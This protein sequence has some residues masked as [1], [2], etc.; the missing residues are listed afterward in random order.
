M[1]EII[2]YIGKKALKHVV[3]HLVSDDNKLADKIEHVRTD[4]TGLTADVARIDRRVENVSDKLGELEDHVEADEARIDELSDTVAGM[5]S[6]KGDVDAIKEII[7]NDASPSNQLADKAYVDD[8]GE[9]L[10]AH[11]LGSDIYGSPF[12][13]YESL[14]PADGS[15]VDF[16]YQGKVVSPNANDVTVVTYD[17][18][19]ETPITRD[20]ATTR[21]RYDGTQWTFEYVIN[22]NALSRSQLLAINSGITPELNTAYSTHVSDA[23]LP[24]PSYHITS[25]ER[26]SW[27]DKVSADDL[28][29]ERK[30]RAAADNA[31]IDSI[32]AE[33]ELRSQADSALDS[34]ITALDEKIDR[35]DANGLFVN[36]ECLRYGNPDEPGESQETTGDRPVVKTIADGNGVAYDIAAK[37]LVDDVKVELT[38]D[39]TGTS[40]PWDGSGN[41]SIAAS[42]PNGSITNGKLSDGAVTLSKIHSDVKGTSIATGDSDQLVTVGAVKSYVDEQV[43]GTGSY[44]GKKTVS[45]I[46]SLLVGGLHNGDR[47]M[48]VDYGTIIHGEGGQEMT[49]QPGDDLILY[50][51]ASGEYQWQVMNG[52]FK[53]KGATLEKMM[54]GTEI[55]TSLKQDANGDLTVATSKISSA[56]SDSEGIVKLYGSTGTATDG[57]MTQKAVSDALS[58]MQTEI[59]FDGTYDKTSNKVA[60]VSS[61]TSRIGSLDAEITSMDGKNVQVTVTQEDGKLTAVNVSDLSASAQ[62]LADETDA[63]KEGDEALDE[64]VTGLEANAHSHDADERAALQSGITSDKV[65]AYDDHLVNTT[66]HITDD[67]RT[68]WNAKQ[69]AI[70]DLKS[71]RSGAAK[72]ST[73]VQP[74][75]NLSTLTDDI[76]VDA[77]VDTSSAPISGIGVKSAIGTL[78]SVAESTDGTNV[79]VKVTQVA[80]KITA[81]NITADATASSDDLDA[82]I[83]ERKEADSAIN[84]SIGKKQDILDVEY[85]AGSQSLTFNNVTISG[86]AETAKNDV[87]GIFDQAGNEFSFRDGV[88]RVD[89]LPEVDNGTLG[90]VYLLSTDSKFYML[91][92]DGSEWIS[93]SYPAD[94]ELDAESTNAIQ[95]KAVVEAI[96]DLYD[97]VDERTHLKP[98][99]TYTLVNPVSGNR[100]R[101][102]KVGNTLWMV[103]NLDE[104]V[105]LLA[106]DAT[107]FKASNYTEAYYNYDT[108]TYGHGSEYNYGR[109]YKF[110]SPDDKNALL[111]KI[112]QW[113][114]VTDSGD[115]WHVPSI[116]E[117]TDL[118]DRAQTMH[119]DCKCWA[120]LCKDPTNVAVPKDVL[121]VS[122]VASG[123]ITNSTGACTD[124][125]KLVKLAVTN[126]NERAVFTCN[127]TNAPSSV[128][129]DVLQS[130]TG[131]P[132]HTLCVRLCITLN[133][134]GSI[135]SKFSSLVEIEKATPSDTLIRDVVP[136]TA[137]QD[138]LLVTAADIA[139]YYDAKTAD[140]MTTFA[141]EYYALVNPVSKNSYRTVRVG[142]LLWLAENLDETIG[143]LATDVEHWV[144][145]TSTATE[146]YYDFDPSTAHGTPKN[147]GRYYKESVVTNNCSVINA[148]LKAWNWM[149]SDGTGWHVPTQ[150]EWQSAIDIALAKAWPKGVKNWAVL[151]LHERDDMQKDAVGL[152]LP[153][154]GRSGNYAGA[155]KDKWLYAGEAGQFCVA[156]TGKGFGFNAANPPDN[157]ADGNFTGG[158]GRARPIRLCLQLN[159]DGSLPDKFK[160]LVTT[161]K[162]AGALRIKE[163]IPPLANPGNPLVTKDE[164]A[165]VDAKLSDYD[166]TTDALA[167]ESEIGK[168]IDDLDAIKHTHSNL[169]LLETYTQTEANLADAVAKK[170]RH[171][172]AD[173]LDEINGDLVE[174]WDDAVD[175]AHVHDNKDLLD[176]YDQANIDIADAVNKKH[177]HTDAQVAAMESG[178]TKTKV[179]S[180]DAHLVN[181]TVHITAAE[182]TAWNGKQDKL[183]NTDAQIQDAVSQSHTH[184]NADELAKI[185]AGDKAKWDAKQD[186][187]EFLTVSDVDT[188][189]NSVT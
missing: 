9:R 144:N 102:V 98:D 50:K 49:V 172:N 128:S 177:A 60:T 93:I 81:V 4:L 145:S 79:Q 52:N 13:T 42:I 64:R 146:A 179:E 72:G 133:T 109:N 99:C 32:A 152:A 63:R 134:D 41:L 101:T 88:H 10:E 100:Y 108:A 85:D 80:G 138:N 165:A 45:Q 120:M 129:G 159:D 19:H 169:D 183:T 39:V 84:E 168:R 154:S 167:R 97:Y 71:I 36:D 70:A 137:T 113:G 89:E 1:A 96:D 31:I 163:V 51:D 77:Y 83:S 35:L 178:V 22:N 189:W 17:T 182:R 7:P 73:A 131:A 170:H 16:Y 34:K 147:Y 25:A 156:N 74:G 164:L 160:A 54:D 176:T 24:H 46:N 142:N 48:V 69:D 141:S 117:F 125:G 136:V 86:T 122:F 127:A 47:V 115:G 105:G 23:S 27:N 28:D 104:D 12:P 161:E 116:A 37:R 111:E 90:V 20:A 29:A 124:S 155:D 112:K 184:L 180:Y 114:W 106:T 56:T 91:S 158:A 67:E 188:I 62:D 38:G 130:G 181:T 148:K 123:S 174:S 87:S 150:A 187:L 76:T 58:K 44:L 15:H 11:Y 140:E 18:R 40:Q 157:N 26:E 166:L 14:F 5:S 186:A 75:D 66:V 8:L 92:D 2:E 162:Y 6:V 175:K 121:G 57:A 153:L 65:G 126:T 95:N 94:P 151:S 139:D 135:P 173:V 82:E 103:E 78:G 132:T 55:I 43:S 185:A 143:I 21:Y 30:V 3:E 149:L 119:P 110:R 61:I 53:I 33:S 118:I 171:E 59:E 107:Q 68:A